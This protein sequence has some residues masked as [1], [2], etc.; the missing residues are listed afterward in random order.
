[1]PELRTYARVIRTIPG[2]TPLTLVNTVYP[3]KIFE[4][5]RKTF[6]RLSVDCRGPLWT[7][8]GSM[9]EVRI[10]GR[11][12]HWD[13]TDW[14]TAI[15][16]RLQR[17]IYRYVFNLNDPETEITVSLKL[18][19]LGEVWLYKARNGVAQSNEEADI[20]AIR[21][22]L[23]ATIAAVPTSGRTD[24]MWQSALSPDGVIAIR[25]KQR[26]VSAAQLPFLRDLQAKF[27][28]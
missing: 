21:A 18:A 3:G 2:R 17:H 13:H 11:F 28:E 27:I 22:A 9:F 6:V 5:T 7:G 16:E 20:D 24:C 1:M 19:E 8:I 23:H 4:I 26:D 12:E 25:C 10:D 15:G 14:A